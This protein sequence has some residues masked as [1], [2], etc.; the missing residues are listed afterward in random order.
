M[1]PQDVLALSPPRILTQF[2]APASRCQRFSL[3]HHRFSRP[4][5]EEKTR[6]RLTLLQPFVAR[7]IFITGHLTQKQVHPVDLK[8]RFTTESVTSIITNLPQLVPMKNFT[9]IS[10]VAL[11]VAFLLGNCSTPDGQQTASQQTTMTTRS[12]K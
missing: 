8:K 2:S 9:I 5:I 1:S 6:R 10:L 4:C 3:L 7:I 12:G 11:G